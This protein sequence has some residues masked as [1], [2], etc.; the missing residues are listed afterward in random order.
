MTL[1]PE[2]EVRVAGKPGL[3]G[4]QWIASAKCSI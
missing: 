3:K 2:F 1:L 4:D